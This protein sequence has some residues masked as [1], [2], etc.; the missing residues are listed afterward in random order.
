[1]FSLGFFLI[2]LL[3]Y[4][5]KSYLISE[6]PRILMEAEGDYYL[7]K[8]IATVPELIYTIDTGYVHLINHIVGANTIFCLRDLKAFINFKFTEAELKNKSECEVD[9]LKYSKI[10]N[11]LTSEDL[12]P[13]VKISF[14]NVELLVHSNLQLKIEELELMDYLYKSGKMNAQGKYLTD[15]KESENV[16]KA[17]FGVEILDTRLVI[18][19]NNTW[20]NTETYSVSLDKELVVTNSNILTK[21]TSK[22]AITVD[23]F[24]PHNLEAFVFSLEFI[25]KVPT[26]TKDSR[27]NEFTQKKIEIA[28]FVYVP[29]FDCVTVEEEEDSEEEAVKKEVYN[30]KLINIDDIM[31]LHPRFANVRDPN[32]NRLLI[33]I[34]TT[35]CQ[36]EDGGEESSLE[37]DVYAIEL[38]KIQEAPTKMLKA[39]N[40]KIMKKYK[41][42]KTKKMK[43]TEEVEK[44][45]SS[46]GYLTDDFKTTQK[47][48]DDHTKKEQSPIKKDFD[49]K[50]MRFVHQL[51][52]LERE[53]N[54]IADKT[55]RDISR[56]LRTTDDAKRVTWQDQKYDTK[57]V[58]TKRRP[59]NAFVYDS[60]RRAYEEELRNRCRSCCSKIK[61]PRLSNFSPISAAWL[62]DPALK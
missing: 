29:L 59:P 16:R 8:K 47:L 61:V 17:E 42:L 28:E 30:F 37:E 50:Y 23:K 9:Q 1:M 11:G 25:I 51:E 56:L 44:L 41:E 62:M 49:N 6:S 32:D 26:Y 4:D 27:L 40:E 21:Y 55:L 19:V 14:S 60:K 2:D 33:N 18:N 43:E 35:M 39:K 3:N 10:L 13:T 31:E 22:G 24:E 53:K 5:N 52:D 12:Y 7:T 46:I 57:N 36:K 58:K 38:K 15:F 20:K 48:Y 45:R 54:E 34:L